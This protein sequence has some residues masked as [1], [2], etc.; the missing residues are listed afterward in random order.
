MTCRKADAVFC[1]T[2]QILR[3]TLLRFT[4]DV[5]LLL[6]WYLHT[7]KAAVSVGFLVYWLW[8]IS[9]N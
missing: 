2:G 7:M 5:L 4:L 1:R 6:R 9:E 3:Q 8:N